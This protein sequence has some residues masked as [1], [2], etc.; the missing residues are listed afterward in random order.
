MPKH[1]VELGGVAAALVQLQVQLRGIEDDGAPAGRALRCRQAAPRPP[2]PAARRDPAG[3]A[4]GC[5]RSRPPGS[6]RRRPGYVRRCSSSPSTAL[7]SMPA[8]HVGD[9]LVRLGA[10]RGG[11]LLPLPLG[12][13]WLVSREGDAL[14]PV[15]GRV[16]RQQL[17]EAGVHG[18]GEGVLLHRR[19]DSCREP[20]GRSS[21]RTGVRSAV[22]EA[23]AMRTASAATRSAS[24]PSSRLEL[25]K[26]QAP[27]ARTR[28]PKP[29]VSAM[30]TACTRPDLT[31][32]CS[33]R[34]R[35]T[36]TSAK[37]AP[38]WVA[39]SRARRQM[40]RMGGVRIARPA[41]PGS[42]GG[43]EAGRYGGGVDQPLGSGPGGAGRGPSG[44][45]S[46]CA[47]GRQPGVVEGPEVRPRG[48]P[49]GL[50]VGDAGGVALDEPHQGVLAVG[51]DE[52]VHR[53]D[54]LRV[55]QAEALAGRRELS[56][57]AVQRDDVSRAGGVGHGAHGPNRRSPA[58][59]TPRGPR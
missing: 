44:S 12:V 39:V 15:H 23:R 38:C 11:V 50:V 52:V 4:P 2:R 51:R 42:P 55:G 34:R 19:L 41:R 5:T 35:T 17:L 22:A 33:S 10:V 47:L 36:R 8:A 49:E 7:T 24:R 40:S 45:G 9:D 46:C 14:D 43:R 31:L 53:R 37:L 3:P 56:G 18:D 27:S 58:R 29:S 32:R 48:G 20:G 54:A 25:A 28:T 57:D 21:S 26:P 6:R 16:G 59:G 13:C 30:D 1:A